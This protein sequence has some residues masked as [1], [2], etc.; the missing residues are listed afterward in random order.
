[1]KDDS[2]SPRLTRR[3][4]AR[5][6]GAGIVASL[7]LAGVAAGNRPEKVPVCHKPE[8]NKKNKQQLWLPKQAAEAHKKNH[9]YDFIGKCKKK[10]KKPC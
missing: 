6:A 3:S 8:G 5:A 7:G 9:K 10:K 4:L 1:M 2:K